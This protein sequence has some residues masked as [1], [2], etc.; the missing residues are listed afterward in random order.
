MLAEPHGFRYLEAQFHPAPTQWVW[1]C[2]NLAMRASGPIAGLLQRLFE[3]R[4]VFGGGLKPLVLLS[5]FALFDSACR[6]ATGC[7]SNMTAVFQRP[8]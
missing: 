2:H 4:D 3:P 5:A 7:T 8:S 1:T 6:L